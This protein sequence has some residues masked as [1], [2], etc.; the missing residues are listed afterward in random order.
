MAF[1]FSY[2]LNKAKPKPI[3]R[4]HL[5]VPVYKLYSTQFGKSIYDSK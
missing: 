4:S 1:K 5:V 2:T 3:Y